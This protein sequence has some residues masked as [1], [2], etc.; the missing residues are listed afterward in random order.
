MNNLRHVPF[1][2]LRWLPGIG[3]KRAPTIAARRPILPIQPQYRE[4]R[5]SPVRRRNRGLVIGEEGEE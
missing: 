2:A 4:P 5:S 1:E 3:K